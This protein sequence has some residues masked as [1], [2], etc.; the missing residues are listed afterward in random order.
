MYTINEVLTNLVTCHA[1]IM[2]ITRSKLKDVYVT[3][4]TGFI[5]Q[6]EKN[7]KDNDQLNKHKQV[8]LMA[9]WLIFIALMVS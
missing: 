2:R 3:I 6:L 4:F 5:L 1:L 9:I 7:F 8:I